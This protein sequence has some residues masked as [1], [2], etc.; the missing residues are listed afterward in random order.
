MEHI[1]NLFFLAAAALCLY[2]A[3]FHEKIGTPRIAVPIMDSALNT[4]VKAVAK[5]VWHSIT[6]TLAIYGIALVYFALAVGNY[7]ACLIIAANMLCFAIL[8]WY[9]CRKILARANFFPHPWVFSAIALLAI[10]GATFDK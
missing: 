2:G 10:I 5:I 8:F 9:F 4:R 7:A 6:F 3:Y 1:L